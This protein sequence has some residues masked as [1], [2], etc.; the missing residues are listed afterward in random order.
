MKYLVRMYDSPNAAA[1]RREHL[2]EHLEYVAKIMPSILVA[3]ALSPEG[4]VKAGSLAVIE[5]PD[6][7]ALEQLIIEDPY[8][9]HGIWLRYEAQPYDPIVGAWL[10]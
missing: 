10:D 7:S 5:V 4:E 2:A 8:Y 9:R 3:G 6:R 1:L